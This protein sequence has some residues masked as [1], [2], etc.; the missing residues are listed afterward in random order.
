MGMGPQEQLGEGS[1]CRLG[2]RGTAHALEREMGTV[3][4][5]GGA[6][7]W[8]TALGC[9]P[10]RPASQEQLGGGGLHPSRIPHSMCFRRQQA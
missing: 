8:K 1:D 10:D 3:S 7:S 2:H 4:A 6:G 9:L 5:L